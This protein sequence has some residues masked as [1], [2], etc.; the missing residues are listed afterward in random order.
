MRQSHFQH[1]TVDADRCA[2]IYYNQN[3]VIV[4][5]GES[6]LNESKNLLQ[7]T[8]KQLNHCHRALKISGIILCVDINDLL[9]AEPLQF[10]EHSKA[11]TQLLA[12]FGQSLNYRIDTA[13]IFTRL[14]ALAGFCEFFQNDHSSGNFSAEPQNGR[15]AFP[16]F[17]SV[18]GPAHG[19][20]SAGRGAD[21]NPN[22]RA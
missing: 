5:L 7:Y 15:Q 20:G 6:W 14:D 17:A 18:D 21:R 8:L 4:E 16:T 3:G 10:A 11:H 19:R 9:V 22:L 1:Y 13:I 2:D 12:R